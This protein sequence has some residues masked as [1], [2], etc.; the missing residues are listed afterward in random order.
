MKEFDVCDDSGK[1]NV[2]IFSKNCKFSSLMEV[3]SRCET[4]S[5]KEEPCISAKCMH[6]SSDQAPSQRKAHI[7]LNQVGSNDI[8]DPNYRL[9]GFGLLHFCKN[10]ISSLPQL[11]TY[12]YA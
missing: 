2:N 3:C 7:Q 1:V 5:L 9:Y 4:L 11:Q 12:I 6:M 10:C 8:K